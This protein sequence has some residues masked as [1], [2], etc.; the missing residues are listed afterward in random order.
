MNKPWRRVVVHGDSMRPTLHPGDRLLVLRLRIRPGDL[1]AIRTPDRAVVKR[2][3][4]VT[5]TGVDAA[6]DNPA[7]STDYLSV[8]RQDVIGR[9]VY[10]YA[11]SGR[12]G[13]LH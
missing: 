4:A 7:A 8:P 2:V 11:P 13:R 6:G 3:T 1:V 5:P 12:I 9:A 10:G